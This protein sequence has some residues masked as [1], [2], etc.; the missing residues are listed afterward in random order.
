ML[1]CIFYWLFVFT[2]ISCIL[3]GISG[4]QDPLIS[5]IRSFTR[6]KF[7]RFSLRKTLLV[8]SWSQL[9]PLLASLESTSELAHFDLL[10]LI[11]QQDHSKSWSGEDV[12]QTH[13]HYMIGAKNTVSAYSSLRKP[14]ICS[15]S[16]LIS[17]L[18]LSPYFSV[19]KEEEHL[20]PTASFFILR[21]TKAP[22]NDI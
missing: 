15:N 20:V 7:L 10:E 5:A 6:S 18:K 11:L 14:N 3:V 21:N 13:L 16:W 8:N 4:S 12:Q 17:T 2:N 9:Y 19:L 22:C 1:K